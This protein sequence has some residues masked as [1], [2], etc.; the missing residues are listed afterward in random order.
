MTKTC[1]TIDIEAGL[2]TLLALEGWSASAPPIPATLGESLPHVAITR[3]GGSRTLMVQDAHSVALD[4]YAATEAGAM[5]AA[6]E[7]TAWAVSL[8]AVGGVPVH[9]VELTALP[10]DNPDPRHPNIARATFTVRILT[11]TAHN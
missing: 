7:L 1:R 3:T 2:Q 6:D 4:V 11:R 10:Y 9:R 8:T 5:E